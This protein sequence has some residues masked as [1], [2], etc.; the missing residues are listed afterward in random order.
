MEYHEFDANVVQIQTASTEVKIL[1]AKVKITNL[2][3]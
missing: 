3:K 1:R 2:L